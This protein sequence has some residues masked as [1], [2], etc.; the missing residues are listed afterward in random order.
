MEELW[1]VLYQLKEDLL[2]H[3]TEYTA[4]MSLAKDSLINFFEFYL[5]LDL[6]LINR[7]N[8]YELELVKKAAAINDSFM[9][10]IVDNLKVD[11]VQ[12]LPELMK[13]CFNRLI[14]SMEKIR[15][16]PV[17]HIEDV[18][19]QLAELQKDLEIYQTSTI[20][21]TDFFM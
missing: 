7:G 15:D 12:Y 11:V 6:P 8:V 5:T 21:D 18:L 1:D 10:E 20:M 4:K 13:E 2:T 3:F 19:E 9:Q 16:D 17:K 14:K